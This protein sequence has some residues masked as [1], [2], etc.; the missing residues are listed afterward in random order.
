MHC[1]QKMH[2]ITKNA[3]YN[4]ED[5]QDEN[6]YYDEEDSAEKYEIFKHNVYEGNEI[7]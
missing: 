4:K 2:W 3:L 1:L 7:Y 6:F 5:L